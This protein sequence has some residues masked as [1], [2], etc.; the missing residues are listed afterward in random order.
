MNPR[1]INVSVLYGTGSPNPRYREVFDSIDDLRLLQEAQDPEK[2]LSQNREDAPDLLLVELNGSNTIPDWL[3]AI[4]AGLP[5][6]EIM[7]C[8]QCRDPDFLIKIMKLRAGGFI[9]LPLKREEILATLERLRAERKERRPSQKQVL[10]VTG[11]KGGVGVTSIA[12]NLAVALEEF[13]P[14]EVI[15]MDLARPFPHVGQFLDL[16]CQH[17]IKDLAN[18]ADNLDE[19]FLKKIVQKHK[20][21]LEVILNHPNWEMHSLITPDAGAIGKILNSLRSTYNWVV[22]DLG[23]WLDLF[24]IRVLQEADQILLVTELTVPD[25]QNARTIKAL[26][27]EWGL[28]DHEVKILVN[29]FEKH[30]ALGLKDLETI[31]S[32]A[33]FY[34][35]PHEYHPLME[36][37]NQGETLKESAPR[38]KVWRRI[39]GLAAELVAQGGSDSAASG[40]A[41][42]G[43]LKRIFS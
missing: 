12:T 22:I 28:Q 25:L 26:Y 1:I 5:Q 4:I 14:G 15:L 19:M 17:S 35:I 11:T 6:T 20:S 9:T 7:V 8:S 43:L 30:Y 39:K 2:F 18:S 21:N 41:R 24:Y 36:A 42:P 34:T 10:A 38:S 23:S 32:R 37:I 27:R 13:K 40:V 16:Q 33:S 3:N 29:H 31:F